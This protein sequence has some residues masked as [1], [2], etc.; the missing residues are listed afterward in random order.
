MKI[1]NKL[2][3][4][5]FL[6]VLPLGVLAVFFYRTTAADIHF[7]RSE[8]V[9]MQMVKPLPRLIFALQKRRGSVALARGG[10]GASLFEK[11]TA[12]ARAAIREL[13]A[14]ARLTELESAYGDAKARWELL[15]SYPLKPGS[16]ELVNAHSETIA[17]T[18]Q[19]IAQIGEKSLIDMD[20]EP[21]AYYVLQMA[22]YDA[23]SLAEAVAK[24]RYRGALYLLNDDIDRATIYRQWG[25][26]DHTI[27]VLES[28]LARMQGYLAP[29]RRSAAE[30]LSQEW[31]EV[32]QKFIAASEKLFTKQVAYGAYF[33]T[34]T[35]VIEKLEKLVHFALQNADDAIAK[36]LKLNVAK[37]V[38]ALALVALGL[39]LSAIVGFLILRQIKDALTQSMITAENLAS[40]E[41]EFDIFVKSHDEI[42]S[43]LRSLK[44]MVDRLKEVLSQVRDSANEIA[45]AA[46]QVASTA[47]ML[48]N[49]AMDQAAH[50]EETGAA[51]GEMVKL[52]ESNARSAV[53]TDATAN[54][55]MQ[56]TQSGAENV[57][58]AVE[59]M[60]M[61]ADKIQIVQEI[62]SQ[63]NL[64][65]L[66]ATIEAARAGEHGRGFAV[67]ATEVG[68]LADTSGQAA[69]QIQALVKESSTI[70]ENAAQSLKL[71]TDSMQ[72]TARKVVAIREASEEQNQ[73]A[74]QISESMARL[75]QTTEQTA[76]AAEELAATAEEMSSQTTA[77]LEN[78]KFFRFD[79]SGSGI[80]SSYSAA[81]AIEKLAR[82][83]GVAEKPS[84]VEGQTPV[85]ANP[86]AYE[87]F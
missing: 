19:Y 52:I 70:A 78:L 51:L 60:K 17:Y 35:G 75:N 27:E 79:S 49:G 40:G 10:D 39:L 56:T 53:E 47:E 64:L 9:G 11:A 37:Q 41:L 29:E 21:E 74:K 48:N 58:R 23:L 63:T 83:Q 42:G 5:A 66:N 22:L 68:K 14:T 50:V 16:A 46:G 12:E 38:T 43:F 2:T 54:H 45:L 33:A 24:L 67:V 3:L 6:L 13:D 81:A 20:P 4:A 82:Q 28:R 8:R 61:I 76:S 15:L 26:A 86:E 65:A 62:A 1:Q 85:V 25:V 57:L 18:L 69:K 31:Q 80:A 73:A 77:L 30:A 59:A 36:R 32:K 71:I 55:A 72:E 44:I 7:A 87:K 34:L 84:L